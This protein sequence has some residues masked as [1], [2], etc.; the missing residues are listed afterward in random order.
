MAY[1]PR[2]L[3][4]YAPATKEHLPEGGM[5]VSALC[6]ASVELSDNTAANLLLASIGGPEGLTR[7]ARSLGDTVTRLDRTEP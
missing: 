4:D 2:D 5:T 3:L 6:A 1:G 7:Y